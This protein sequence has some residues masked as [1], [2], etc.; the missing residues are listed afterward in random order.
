MGNVSILTVYSTLVRL[1]DHFPQTQRV[2]NIE[3]NMA[4]PSGEALH[5]SLQMTPVKNTVK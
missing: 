5:L 1:D 3:K 4:P 2:K